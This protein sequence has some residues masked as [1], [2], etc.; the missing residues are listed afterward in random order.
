M[1][2]KG[3]I[4]YH[5]PNNMFENGPRRHV[6]DEQDDN[7]IVY[8]DGYSNCFLYTDMIFYQMENA[9]EAMKL[10]LALLNLRELD[11]KVHL[12]EIAQKENEKNIERGKIANIIEIITEGIGKGVVRYDRDGFESF[13]RMAKKDPQWGVLDLGNVKIVPSESEIR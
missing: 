2:M 5:F 3:D 10:Q 13:C 7:G 1:Y 12:S 6:V 11:S 9:L 8:V 4:I